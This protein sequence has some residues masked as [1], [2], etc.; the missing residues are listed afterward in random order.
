MRNRLL[1]GAACLSAAVMAGRIMAEG[2]VD[3]VA[4]TETKSVTIFASPSIVPAGSVCRVETIP[5]RTNGPDGLESDDG[6]TYTG[7]VLSSSDA[8]IVIKATEVEHRVTPIVP[9]EFA[10]DPEAR[11]LFK[12]SGVKRRH[13][14]GKRVSVPASEIRTIRISELPSPAAR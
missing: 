4:S 14:E 6:V 10:K 11:R 8:E 13:P 2:S 3:E 9:A 1:L 12:T 7:E 5:K